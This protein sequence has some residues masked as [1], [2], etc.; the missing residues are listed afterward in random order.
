MPED[1]LTRSEDGLTSRNQDYKIVLKGL[2]IENYALYNSKNALDSKINAL[3]YDNYL[4]TFT[5]MFDHAS[6]D[7]FEFTHSKC[8]CS[9]S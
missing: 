1:H 3:T 4:K 8:S 2:Y 5:K 7:L 6:N 9:F